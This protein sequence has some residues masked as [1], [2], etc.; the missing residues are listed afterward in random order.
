MARVTK[1]HKHDPLLHSDMVASVTRQRVQSALWDYD[2][3]VTEL[4]A[5][6]GVDRLPYLVDDDTR[7][8]WWSAVDKLN[9]AV[10]EEDAE[11]VRHRV[12]VCLRGLQVLEA[13]AERDG[14]IPMGPTW[15]EIAME[16]G[17][18]LRVV[19][20]WPEGSMARQAA[21]TGQGRPKVVVWSLHEVA[22]VIA[23]YGAVNSAK[24][25]WPGASV[26]KLRT[27]TEEELDDDIPF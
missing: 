10:A 2:R 25:T 14:Q 27:I 5:K 17:S 18:V 7:Q 16:D 11:A 3:A 19:K 21:E 6:W 24:A 15:W 1:P 26:A 20:E 22:R 4:E 8:K 9:A 23:A 12:D 13:K